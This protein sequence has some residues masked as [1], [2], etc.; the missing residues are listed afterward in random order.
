MATLL[1]VSLGTPQLLPGSDAPTG[2]VKAPRSGPVLVDTLGLVGDAVLNRKYHGGPDQALYLYLQQDYDWWASELGTPFAPG[3]FGEN[4]TVDGIAGE[5]L[6][7]GDR[8]TIGD[9]VLEATWHR[10]PCN[11]LARR[12]GDPR[13]VKIFARAGRPGA[14]L[15]VLHPGAIEAG[16]EVV[17]T[18]FAGERV[19]VGELMSHDGERVLP[20]TFVRRMLQTP[21]RERS[22]PKYEALLQTEETPHEP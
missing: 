4:L 11:T 19:T 22:R 3:T 15:R 1:A 6:A 21:L 18:P 17:H 5:A 8:F 2:I 14:Y 20:E 16:M 7:I 13:W 12:M 9:V 10:T